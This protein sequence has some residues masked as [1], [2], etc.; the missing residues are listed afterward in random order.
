M[1]VDKYWY[2][3]FSMLILCNLH[4]LRMKVICMLIVHYR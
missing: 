4:V 3:L 1:V 2:I